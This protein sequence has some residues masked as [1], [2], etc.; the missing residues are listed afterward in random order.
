MPCAAARRRVSRSCARRSIAIGEPY[1]RSR[2]CGMCGGV[3]LTQRTQSLSAG[4]GLPRRAQ[5]TQ[6]QTAGQSAG[7]GLT[8]SARSTRSQTAGLSAGIGLTRSARSTR[9]MGAGFVS[10]AFFVLNFMRQGERA[11]PMRFH[12]PTASVQQQRGGRAVRDFKSGPPGGR[13][14]PNSRNRES[15]PS[16]YP[17]PSRTGRA[18]GASRRCPAW[19]RGRR[20]R[21]RR[22]CSG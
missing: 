2:S 22:G 16:F 13:T 19:R 3:E 10:F 1:T 14:L 12:A 11:V 21:P 20:R 9:S 6:S 7:I 5:R 8:R 17:T 15:V 18:R 4:I